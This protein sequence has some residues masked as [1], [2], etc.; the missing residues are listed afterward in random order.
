M[1][2]INTNN[3]RNRRMVSGALYDFLAHLMS[4]KDPITMGESEMITPA[5]EVFL[6]WAQSRGLDVDDNPDIKGWNNKV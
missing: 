1:K 2:T 6:K 4:L 5:I 3:V